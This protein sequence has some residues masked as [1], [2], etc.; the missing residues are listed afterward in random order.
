MKELLVRV[1]DKVSEGSPIARLDVEERRRK[2]PTRRAGKAGGARRGARGARGEAPA[3]EPGERARA[4]RRRRSALPRSFA[5]APSDLDARR[6][7]PRAHASP[8]VRRLARELGVDLALV[9]AERARR[10]A[11]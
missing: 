9:P 2:R 10:A 7:A 1:G 11:S 6:R 3:R 4:A 8:S 5:L